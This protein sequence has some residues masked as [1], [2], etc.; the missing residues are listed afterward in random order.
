MPQS[1]FRW[2]RLVPSDALAVAL[3]LL[4]VVIGVVTPLPLGAVV[5]FTLLGIAFALLTFVKRP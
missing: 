3:I 4:A 5:V 1:A 2:P